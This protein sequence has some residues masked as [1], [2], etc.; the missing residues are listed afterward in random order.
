MSNSDHLTQQILL[1]FEECFPNENIDV[2]SNFFDLGGDSLKVVSLCA[3]IESKV[4]FEIDTSS[5]LFHPTVEELA[6][7]IERCPSEADL[8]TSN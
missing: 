1:A 4:G 3:S 5:L 6:R 7:L 8:N 2:E